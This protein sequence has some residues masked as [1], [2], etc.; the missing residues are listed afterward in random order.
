MIMPLFLPFAGKGP[1]DT[2]K[3]SSPVIIFSCWNTMAGSAIV[4]LPWAFQTAGLVMGSLISLSSFLISYYTCTLII[5]TAKKDK[6]YLFTLKK[7]YGKPGYY[8]GIFGSIV[9]IFG[10]LTVYFVVVV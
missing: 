10:A 1:K 6:D 9:L 5:E 2:T 3:I 4:S 7:Y 8:T